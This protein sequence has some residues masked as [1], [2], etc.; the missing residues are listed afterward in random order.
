MQ[1][2]KYPSRPTRTWRSEGF[3]LVAVSVLLA[4][5][6]PGRGGELLVGLGQGSNWTAVQNH[7]Q[8]IANSQDSSD[9]GIE[10]AG[11]TGETNFDDQQVSVSFLAGGG[12]V[13]IA[14]FSD[15]GV[16]VSVKD[17][18]VGGSETLLSNKGTP[19]PLGNLS[20]S[21]HTLEYDFQ[22]DHAYRLTV[23][24]LNTLYTG[25]GDIDGALLIA[26]A[27][28]VD[29]VSTQTLR[30]RHVT[31]R[32]GGDEYVEGTTVKYA[33]IGREEIFE[34]VPTP[35]LPAG[36]NPYYTWKVEGNPLKDYILTA[37]LGHPVPLV[38]ADLLDVE[39]IA[40]IWAA[41]GTY[42]I[43]VTTPHG[44]QVLSTS[45][46]VEVTRP[47]C[48]F[49]GDAFP[50]EP[51]VATY[52]KENG[53][54]TFG[55]G[56]GAEPGMTLSGTIYPYSYQVG[57]IGLT[58]LVRY[59]SSY[60]KDGDTYV[61]SQNGRIALI[62][63]PVVRSTK[64]APQFTT[65]DGTPVG[66]SFNWPRTEG[67]NTKDTHTERS[68]SVEYGEYLMYRPSGPQG[69]RTLWVP[70]GSLAWSWSGDAV[71]NGSSGVTRGWEMVQPNTSTLEPDNPVGHLAAPPTW[72]EQFD[73]GWDRFVPENP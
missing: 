31:R 16:T 10:S 35:P 41:A 5:P 56:R 7:A 69:R 61:H 71:K 34:V 30:V 55:P 23:D 29:E 12:G 63:G 48:T 32:T 51:P 66:T 70:L 6:Q 54:V 28:T 60:V 21:L 11:A 18:T 49:E 4:V 57:Q 26:Y 39:Q 68:L 2:P 24:Y 67:A 8:A 19:Q 53:G 14:A 40:P 43:T 38:G 44:G 17:L 25:S 3:L 1:T 9:L 73:L 59:D 62:G 37:N 45:F 47:G 65:V 46:N 58:T 52:L 20:K 13:K 22:D 27:G 33:V 50:S 36:A 15:D 42:K 64:P 72:T